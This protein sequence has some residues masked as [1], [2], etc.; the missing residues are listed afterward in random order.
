MRRMTKF[1]DKGIADLRA[2]NLAPVNFT[3]TPE[4]VLQSE[5]V[6]LIKENMKEIVKEMKKQ[7]KVAEADNSRNL[8]LSEIFDAFSKAYSDKNAQSQTSSCLRDASAFVQRLNDLMA[9]LEENVQ[10][11]LCT[12]METFVTDGLK[13]AIEQKRQYDREAM[14]Y[15]NMITKHKSLKKSGKATPQKEKE[16]E[17]QLAE[18]REEYLQT[19][20]ATVELMKQAAAKGEMLT[21]VKLVE[22]WDS[23]NTF[24]KD[25]VRFLET[26]QPK[27]E[28]Y[29][30]HLRD[31]AKPPASAQAKVFKQPIEKLCERENRRVPQIV[32]ACCAYL[33]VHGLD[34]QG[35][36]RVSPT[37]DSLDEL[38]REIDQG[39]TYNFSDVSNPH[40]ISGLLK[41]FFRETPEPIF[42]LERYP[43]FMEAS[44]LPTT[45]AQVA[46]IAKLLQSLPINSY[47]SLQHVSRLCI[48]IDSHKEEN[49]MNVS[50]LATVLTPNLLYTTIMDP[51]TMVQEMEQANKIYTLIV[52]NYNEMFPEDD[53]QQDELAPEANTPRSNPVSPR[54]AIISN[55]SAA[56]TTS[57][58]AGSPAPS[59]AAS[60]APSPKL[61]SRSLSVSESIGA[62]LS[63][64]APSLPSP[65]ASSG[66]G[67]DSGVAG[68]GSEASV[69]SSKKSK[70][71]KISSSLKFDSPASPSSTLSVDS[72]VDSDA[73]KRTPR[74]ARSKK[75]ISRSESIGPN[76]PGRDSPAIIL[77]GSPSLAG[78]G[79][80]ESPRGGNRAMAAVEGLRRTVSHRQTLGDSPSSKDDALGTPERSP[81]EKSPRA[82]RSATISITS[83]VSPKGSEESEP[84]AKSP[85]LPASI[86]LDIKKHRKKK[87]LSVSANSDSTTPREG[88]SEIDESPKSP[89]SPKTPKTLKAT[90]ESPPSSPLTKDPTVENLVE[91]H[92][93]SK[94]KKSATTS[95]DDNK[96]D[97]NPAPTQATDEPK[98]PTDS[99][100]EPSSAT[101]SS[102]TPEKG[103]TPKSNAEP[104]SEPSTV[105]GEPLQTS[106]QKSDLPAVVDPSVKEEPLLAPV[107]ISSATAALLQGDKDTSG[108]T[109]GQAESKSTSGGASPPEDADELADA[110]D[111]LG[112]IKSPSMMGEDEEIPDVLPE[113][114]EHV[115]L[116]LDASIQSLNDALFTFMNTGTKDVL[117]AE[118]G[119]AA[120][121][122]AT[123]DLATT[124]RT[125]ATSSGVLIS[126]YPESEEAIEASMQS[127]QSLLRPVVI[128]V[129]EVT[130]AF[131]SDAD[132]SGVTEALNGLQTA[133]HEYA[134]EIYGFN[135]HLATAS[136]QQLLLAAQGAVKRA[137]AIVAP[138]IRAVL[139]TGLDEPVESIKAQM[140]KEVNMALVYSAL[141][142]AQLTA[143]NLVE[144][145]DQIVS[146]VPD[147]MR[148]FWSGVEA[149]LDNP[150][151]Q[152]AGHT[153]VQ[154]AKELIGALRGMETCLVDCV[155]TGASSS[156]MSLTSPRGLASDEDMK[157]SLILA[158]D[159]LTSRVEYGSTSDLSTRLLLA[160][161]KRTI[162]AFIAGTRK[163]GTHLASEQP[164]LPSTYQAYA[165]AVNK[166]LTYIK[167]HRI[168]GVEH[169]PTTDGYASAVLLGLSHARVLAI[170]SASPNETLGSAQGGQTQTPNSLLLSHVLRI[171]HHINKAIF[172]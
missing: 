1:I 125:L 92:D 171:T 77:P 10:Q 112:L 8:H 84:N 115:S 29:R 57:A 47:K 111:D 117:S 37:K 5:N 169:P 164:H 53:L 132:E 36:F 67:D 107:A 104:N 72:D 119:L 83:P 31:L 20:K 38:K 62:T 81:R 46:A 156:V 108:A 68:E 14:D 41:A 3:V 133:T 140:A 76:S 142:T 43:K 168:D 30:R 135:T 147:L 51:L 154:D 151:P 40:V 155:G 42:T 61:H 103:K 4:L 65:L 158:L 148:A 66:D 139:S 23:V 152:E 101:E 99:T 52:E 121:S 21:I 69:A 13:P 97:S 58:A 27:I 149:A 89:K 161:A 159:D 25:G 109:K 79:G 56:S 141:V 145:L 94:S 136:S 33:S 144:P 98:I 105:V 124:A 143:P 12:T 15:D 85:R 70:R 100:V 71:S 96:K 59:S 110:L 26:M 128:A 9:K 153:L 87:Q 18:T 74:S 88:D 86:S 55:S 118:D 28:R 22:Y 63:S 138:T 7:A 137:T 130:S 95:S 78:N 163:F 6:D 146:S 39:R 127:L 122:Q 106:P 60:T 24:F 172:G 114:V 82:E 134:R 157:T 17:Q 167:Y 75:G 54:A 166:L 19:E 90:I 131:S 126:N 16:S 116:L 73:K 80:S 2:A 44:K 50:N 45:E 162:K 123:R 48:L 165:D 34:T 170:L 113:P 160:S 11:V 150:D 102:T 129:K 64:S 120:L 35:I 91:T 49:K 32:V 93:D